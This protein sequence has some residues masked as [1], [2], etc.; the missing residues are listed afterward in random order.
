MDAGEVLADP[1]PEGV[2]PH[3]V[4]GLVVIA[5]YLDGEGDLRL[6]WVSTVPAWRA[7]GMLEAESAECRALLE[8]PADD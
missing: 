2:Q 7:L 6:G 5:E 1:L 3:Q 4:T 8:N